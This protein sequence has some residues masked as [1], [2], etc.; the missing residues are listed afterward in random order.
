VPFEPV[1]KEVP[2]KT[3][4]DYKNF[5]KTIFEIIRDGKQVENLTAFFTELLTGID[6]ADMNAEQLNKI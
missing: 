4:R 5:G 3:E 1:I 2:L 6:K